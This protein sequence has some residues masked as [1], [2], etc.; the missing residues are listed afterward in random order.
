MPEF[1]RGGNRKCVDATVPDEHIDE[2]VDADYLMYVFAHSERSN[3]L[4]YASACGY[5]GPH[6]RPISGSFTI[7]MYHLT[8]AIESERWFVWIETVIH[9]MMHAL[10]FS[11]GLWGYF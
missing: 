2:G 4:A 6:R 7:N 10:G 1:L 5:L 8:G 9:E 3:T 11:P